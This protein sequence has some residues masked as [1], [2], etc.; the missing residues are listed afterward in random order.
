VYGELERRRVEG[1]EV[2]AKME[3]PVRDFS[4]IYVDDERRF[5]IGISYLSGVPSTVVSV[6]SDYF[7]YENGT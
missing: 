1:G 6:A 2:H 5:D 4:V 3:M 7:E